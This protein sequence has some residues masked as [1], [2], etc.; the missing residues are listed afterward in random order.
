MVYLSN[1]GVR[2]FLGLL[3]TLPLLAFGQV[4]KAPPD[5]AQRTLTQM[6]T[7]SGKKRDPSP[8]KLVAV[9]NSID[10]L[11]SQVEK[12][13]RA[14]E[15]APSTKTW[16]EKYGS[17][18][19]AGVACCVFLFSIY[20]AMRSSKMAKDN[21]IIQQRA[22]VAIDLSA[23]F[24]D[25]RFPKLLPIRIVNSGQTPAYRVEV[26]SNWWHFPEQLVRPPADFHYSLGNDDT[27]SV[28]TLGPKGQA[29]IQLQLSPS[30]EHPFK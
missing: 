12:L 24:E 7:E 14:Q 11:S 16:G 8:D 26:K 18:V 13:T 5:P 2:G 9:S 25:S 4:E 21:S 10:N 30:K 19:S 29:D 20:Q 15:T 23:K 1:Q 17:G 3:F 27:G 22:Y 6:S 28:V